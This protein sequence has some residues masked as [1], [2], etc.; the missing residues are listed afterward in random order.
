MKIKIQLD[1]LNCV[2]KSK[3]LRGDFS[4]TEVH[5]SIH[6]SYVTNGKTFLNS[7]IILN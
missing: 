1:R 2:L 4:F 6:V 5:S 7:E 3:L